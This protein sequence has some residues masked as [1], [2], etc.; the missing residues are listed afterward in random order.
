MV[1]GISS[2]GS[3]FIVIALLYSPPKYSVA[4][5]AFVAGLTC[6]Y[7]AVVFSYIRWLMATYRSHISI[8]GRPRGLITLLVGEQAD[9]GY[10]AMF[11]VTAAGVIAAIIAFIFGRA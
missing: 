9:P 5:V 2:L 4:G 3:L 6:A 10:R 1:Q 7:V 8:V 11:L